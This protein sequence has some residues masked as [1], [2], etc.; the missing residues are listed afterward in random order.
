MSNTHKS[1]KK[2]TKPPRRSNRLSAQKQ[3]T[4]AKEANRSSGIRNER[5]ESAIRNKRQRKLNEDEN[6][7]KPQTKK[8]KGSGAGS[9]G[10]N[11]Q[12]QSNK[13]KEAARSEVKTVDRMIENKKKL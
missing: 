9:R 13:I 4:K 6:N 1:H 12:I 2:E 8:R 3:K 10:Q 7:R 11:K 5:I